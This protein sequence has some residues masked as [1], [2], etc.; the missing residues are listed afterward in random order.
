LPSGNGAPNSWNRAIDAGPGVTAARKK[1]A[2]VVI[3]G[4]GEPRPMQT[5][6]KFVTAA[7]TTDRD[8]VDTESC[9]VYSKPDR[10]TGDF[11]L[12]RVTT[13]YPI[14]DGSGWAGQ[15]VDFFEF[16]WAHLTTGATITGISRWVFRLLWRRPMQVPRPLRT[17]WRLAVLLVVAGVS[18]PVLAALPDG[19]R[20]SFIRAPAWAAI[21]VASALLGVFATYF[22]TPFLG[23]VSRYMSPTPD[24]VEARRKIREAGVDLLGKLHASGAYDRII[25]V[26][27][28]LGTVIGCDILNCAWGRIDK[29]DFLAQHRADPAMM[30]ALDALEHAAGALVGAQS[31][32][33][34]AERGRRRSTY[35]AAQR[36]YGR[37]MATPSRSGPGSDKPLWLVS[38]FVTLGS[39]LSKAELLLA[40]DLTAL[41]RRMRLRELPSVPPWLEQLEPPRCSFPLRDRVRSPHHAAIFAPT[42]WTNLYF[43]TRSLIFGDVVG[44]P[45]APLFG[46]GIL[47]VALPTGGW[48]FRHYAYWLHPEHHPPRSW[49]RALRRA[50][51]FRRHDDATLWGEETLRDVVRAERLE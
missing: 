30:R 5:L 16:Y 21:T 42:L 15:R 28:G 39:P 37:A 47:D 25:L 1:V 8:L 35:R 27:H 32:G 12:R 24:N 23:D 34:E 18:F 14:N 46:A 43:P 38:D 29:D 49:I 6:W 3:H 33:G 9:E 2:L 48:R 45:L 13:R 7:W 20:P 41:R 44:G 26:G 31:Q 11:E 40:D 10:I 19:A 17:L 22:L 4:I 50:I 51:N 36:R